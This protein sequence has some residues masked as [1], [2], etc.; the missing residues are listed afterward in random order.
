MLLGFR[1]GV[2]ELC[3]R[4][5]ELSPFLHMHSQSVKSVIV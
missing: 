3:F 4:G 1:F 5:L 2:E